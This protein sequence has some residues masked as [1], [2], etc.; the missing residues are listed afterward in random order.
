MQK[1][2]KAEIK[3]QM[4]QNPHRGIWK[5]GGIQSSAEDLGVLKNRIKFLLK[6]SS[7]NSSKENGT[8]R[9]R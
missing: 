9:K 4:D 3:G 2:E 8:T 7:S 1:N 5:R 6:I